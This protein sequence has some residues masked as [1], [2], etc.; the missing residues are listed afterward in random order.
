MFQLHELFSIFLRGCAK[1]LCNVYM[2]QNGEPTS[3]LKIKTHFPYSSFLS[4]CKPLPL[5]LNL[6]IVRH[7]FLSRLLL[8]PL[9][10]SSKY[11]FFFLIL[12]WSSNR[13][14]HFF[15]YFGLKKFSTS[16]WNIKKGKENRENWLQIRLSLW[17]M[18]QL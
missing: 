17:P 6:P 3:F 12:W 18:L 8:V 1:I 9:P 11:I 5:L 14:Y 2:I 10:L 7:V 16:T 4:R 15:F 13:F